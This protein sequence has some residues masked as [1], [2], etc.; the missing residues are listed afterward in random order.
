MSG[1]CETTRP[2]LVH[3]VQGH[4][5]FTR[6][7]VTDNLRVAACRLPRGEHRPAWRR[8]GTSSS[9]SPRR[10]A[11]SRVHYRAA[12]GINLPWC[13]SRSAGRGCGFLT[14][15]PW[16][17]AITG[18]SAPSVAR[19]LREPGSSVLLV[20][21]LMEMALNLPIASSRWRAVGSYWR[22]WR[23]TQTPPRQL[24]QVYFGQDVS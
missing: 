14:N 21:R 1:P 15:R 10:F 20:V 9:R 12:S 17:L 16:P 6:L 18:R 23:R 11:T 8:N 7:S 2:H 24:V 5:M 19:S 4:G 22:G 13:R 3:I